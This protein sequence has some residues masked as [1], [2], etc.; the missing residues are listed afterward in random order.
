M[1]EKTSFIR[2]LVLGPHVSITSCVKF[3]SYFGAEPMI[4]VNGRD[5][6]KVV[7][8]QDISFW[9]KDVRDPNAEANT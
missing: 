2:G 7:R 3:G 6:R 1:A 9:F 8:S 4:A 5:S